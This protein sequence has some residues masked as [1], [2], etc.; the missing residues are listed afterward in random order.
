MTLETPAAPVPAAPTGQ[1]ARL[2]LETDAP[3]A[4]GEVR[5]ESIRP[6]ATGRDAS[7]QTH[8]FSAPGILLPRPLPRFLQRPLPRF[9][10]RS[11][12]PGE[13]GQAAARL[14]HSR[15]AAIS[16]APVSAAW[17]ADAPLEGIQASVGV[18]NF[19]EETFPW[20]P[21]PDDAASI[22]SAPALLFPELLLRRERGTTTPHA[23]AI[24]EAEP[25]A[26]ANRPAPATR[27]QPLRVGQ[28][29]SGV[30]APRQSAPTFP[31][32]LRVREGETPPSPRR[33]AR[34]GPLSQQVLRRD[35]ADTRRYVLHQQPA[36]PT[37]IAAALGFADDEMS[38]ETMRLLPGTGQTTGA[39][40]LPSRVALAPR[41]VA[42][43]RL[44]RE[45]P[46]RRDFADTPR[47]LLQQTIF[48]QPRS[49]QEGETS[50]VATRPTPGT[51]LAD[52]PLEL[53]RP[54]LYPS[55]LPA[56]T[57]AAAPG[58][59]PQTDALLQRATFPEAPRFREGKS[60]PAATKPTRGA[61]LTATL[62]D[63]TRQAAHRFG[64][65]RTRRDIADTRH[66]LLQRVTTQPP[67]P[68]PP[69]IGEGIVTTPPLIWGRLGGGEQLPVAAAPA[70][71][72]GT[73]AIAQPTPRQMILAPGAVARAALLQT[74]RQQVRHRVEPVSALWHSDLL[75]DEAMPVSPPGR[76]VAG[77]VALSGDDLLGLGGLQR[78]ERAQPRL[79]RTIA[80]ATVTP[81]EAVWAAPV[82]QTVPAARAGFAPL[83]LALHR[84]LGG[85]LPSPA[86]PALGP[87]SGE[88]S[89]P[90]AGNQP[91]ASGRGRGER[92]DDNRGRQ[93]DALGRIGPRQSAARAVER[94]E[95]G[96]WRF[97]RAQTPSA[98]PLQTVQRALAGLATGGS[99][100]IP[101]RPRTLL[102]RVL[103][104]DFAGVRVQ[105][106][107]LG[108]LGIEAAAR[109]NTVY[110]SREQARLDRPE[111][112]ALLGHELTHV[113]ASGAAP[114]LARSTDQPISGGMPGGDAGA[115]L[116]LARPLV[117]SLSRRLSRQLVQMSLAD[118]E[119]TAEAV[120][121]LVISDQRSA[122]GKK[123]LSV[124]NRQ[125]PVA[126]SIDKG[127]R[128]VAELVQRRLS[129]KHFEPVSQSWPGLG[130]VPVQ[131]PGQEIQRVA[132]PAQA[133]SRLELLEDVGWRFKRSEQPTIAQTQHVQRA[134]AELTARPSGGMPLP[135][136]PRT[137]MERVLQR[138]FSG[139]RLQAAGLEPLGV[140]A[141]ARGQTVYL[142]RS[143]L[144]QLERP[145]NLALLGHE[146]THVAAA[147]NPPV[148]RSELLEAA[149]AEGGASLPLPLF[150][151]SVG[152]L[153]RS[154]AHEEAAAVSVEKGIQTL[155]RQSATAQRDPLAP[156][157]AKGPVKAN[158][159]GQI[160]NPIGR[161]GAGAANGVARASLPADLPVAQR[162][163]LPGRPLAA[164]GRAV[165]EPDL[166]R[167]QAE[168]SLLE[169]VSSAGM[170]VVQRF[171][172]RPGSAPGSV[173]AQAQ[174]H[175][176]LTV[177]RFASPNGS[178]HVQ[179][180][181][182]TGGTTETTQTTEIEGDG[183]DEDQEP[184]WDRLAEKIYPL[185]VRMLKM[186]RERR[187]L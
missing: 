130:F 78:A 183:G 5:E 121:R 53:A 27:Q 32:A 125:S 113:A 101:E 87:V 139:V 68:N 38:G 54:L 35:F 76:D 187:P 42:P 177:S 150:L 16:I 123:R 33:V 159:A 136:R 144:A 7:A 127:S 142:Q 153:Q 34:V 173:S 118:E 175:S 171:A 178:S 86:T 44:L 131:E 169:G 26:V 12:R 11:H 19:V 65:P 97:K 55:G 115:E 36:P 70:S 64:L 166:Q 164:L 10:Q 108:P 141:A 155:L 85:G 8:L 99:R 186:E 79:Q 21:A 60:S 48:P 111:S 47:D 134:E 102:E 128:A 28:Q 41:R 81:R 167:V 182:I 37:A 120:E 56:P 72:F 96:G 50:A 162:R 24:Q 61:G 138:D 170:P 66:D 117:P 109:G 157:L 22:A 160:V 151:P 172:E 180:G 106:A 58:E 140:E 88:Q 103:Q 77:P 59:K 95:A 149:Q 152:Q 20:L 83:E 93:K 4:P 80:A 129:N 122:N 6:E 107:S 73:A 69:Q 184:D 2:T 126:S 43:V 116:P 105:M 176:A 119:K 52:T 100:P 137:L 154:V 174:P 135:A 90:P 156:R 168:G 1:S 92:A 124:A 3:A 15:R 23:P 31:A 98:A 49:L 114:L 13:T 39:T 132:S 14:S 71:D 51:R 63:L 146:L 45:E 143:A 148:R 17:A 82:A 163:A 67:H 165:A 158:G 62:L 110:L 18:P 91:A 75:H 25:T 181:A 112:L 185:I 9:L 147:S 179:R 84:L 57:P 74:A 161:N 94:L 30:A 46:L 133:E 104:R 29:P 40:G 89:L 145:D